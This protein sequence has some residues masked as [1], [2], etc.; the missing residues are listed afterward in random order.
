MTEP[1]VPLPF[2]W[3]DSFQTVCH[4]TLGQITRH[5]STGVGTKHIRSPPTTSGKFDV[6]Y[7]LLHT[8]ISAV[9][10]YVLRPCLFTKFT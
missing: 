8:I 2:F 6:L 7:T 5:K 3:K 9:I 10:L 1:R 4:L